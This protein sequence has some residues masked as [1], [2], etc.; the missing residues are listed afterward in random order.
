[1]VWQYFILYKYGQFYVHTIFQFSHHL[2]NAEKRGGKEKEK[3][4]NQIN[5]YQRA[6]IVNIEKV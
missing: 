5:Q 4:V 2:L 1:M 6:F 3:L